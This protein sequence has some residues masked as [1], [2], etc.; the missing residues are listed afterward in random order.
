M[1]P[2]HV[3]M[4]SVCKKKYTNYCGSIGFLRPGRNSQ[5]FGEWADAQTGQSA[6]STE[7]QGQGRHAVG[8]RGWHH[9]GRPSLPKNILKVRTVITTATQPYKI[10]H[11][12]LSNSTLQQT[13]G[14]VAVWLCP[15]TGRDAESIGTFCGRDQCKFNCEACSGCQVI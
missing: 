7:P 12:G 6:F 4:I 11:Q 10:T 1:H 15:H 13:S 5:W 2:S 8:R 14:H 9:I 3:Y